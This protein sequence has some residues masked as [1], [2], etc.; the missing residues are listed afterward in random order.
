MSL[1]HTIFG[2]PPHEREEAIKSLARKA[3][4]EQGENARD[5]F[6]KL[7]R[8]LLHAKHAAGASN[9]EVSKLRREWRALFHKVRTEETVSKVKDK[10]S[11]AKPKETEL[12]I[13]A[14]V[15]AV[16]KQW[17]NDVFVMNGGVKIPFTSVDFG[18]TPFG[19]TV[20][21]ATIRQLYEEIL[22]IVYEPIMRQRQDELFETMAE[23]LTV[24]LAKR[25]SQL[26]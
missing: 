5:E 15:S 22:E 2:L 4:L 23:I 7:I 19:E 11:Q 14:A 25:S 20:N 24:S 17:K 3:L 26:T 12:A 1:S 8:L 21:P 13:A 16:N 6:D 9:Q 18:L 10:S